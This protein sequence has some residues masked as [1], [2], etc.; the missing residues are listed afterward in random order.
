MNKVNEDD[1]MF[2]AGRTTPNGYGFIGVKNDEGKWTS[3]IVHRYIY[4]TTVKDI[5]KEL[6][7]DHLCRNRLCINTDH[8]EPVTNTE[9]LNRGNRPNVWGDYC[10]KGH[11]VFEG[12]YYLYRKMRFC[13][14][15]AREYEAT[16]VR[17]RVNRL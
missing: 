2:W 13:K 8:L 9:N 6:V 5:P 12:S 4:K 7:L 17:P 10:N 14:E 11:K 16:Y 1:C 15:C 3:A